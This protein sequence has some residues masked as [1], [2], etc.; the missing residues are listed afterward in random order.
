MSKII[1]ATVGTPV[2]PSKIEREIKPVKTVNGVAPDANGNVN[3]AG[4]NGSGLPEVTEADNGKIPMVVGGQWENVEFPA[5]TRYDSV[6]VIVSPAD[7]LNNGSQIHAVW[8]GL[9]SSVDDCDVDVSL[10]A[11]STKEQF[12]EAARCGVYVSAAGGRQLTFTAL[13]DIP[14]LVL[15]FDI[16]ITKP[17]TLSYSVDENSMTMT[18]VE[19]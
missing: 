2:S 18:I 1:G 12:E 9:P 10:R 11:S 6:S 14:T 16:R 13:Y 4:G 17:N 5:G 15:I 8:S 7:W 19:G 3:V